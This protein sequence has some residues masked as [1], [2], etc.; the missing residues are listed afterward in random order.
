MSS[1]VTQMSPAASRQTTASNEPS[2][3]SRARARV[4]PRDLHA[5]R[6]APLLDQAPSLAHLLA[7]A[8][9][10]GD[11]TAVAL[12]DAKR[13]RSDAAAHVE[14][15]LL[16]LRARHLGDQIGV[17]VEGLPQRLDPVRK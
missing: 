4:P 17:G 3:E 12:G 9:D 11:V 2:G 16:R 8:V 13:R 1:S 14:N 5:A 6:H 15:A 10:R 7:A